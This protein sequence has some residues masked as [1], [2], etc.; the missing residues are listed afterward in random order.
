VAGASSERNGVPGP[1]NDELLRQ[2]ARAAE[3][4]DADVERDLVRAIAS[5]Q[6]VAPMRADP[7]T[8]ESG[9]WATA[10]PEGRTQ[11]VAF[12]DVAA[13]TAWAGADTPHA[14]V[15]GPEFARI[16]VASDAV[17]LWINPAGPH[18]G[19][20]ERRM[21]DVVAAGETLAF[22]A[23]DAGARTTRLKTTGHGEIRVRR[24]EQSP[25]PEALERLREA[26][27]ASPH[28]HDGRLL[29]ATAPPPVHLLLVLEV[30]PGGDDEAAM[31]DVR[32]AVSRLVP[33]DRFVD[34]M[35]VE[36]GDDEL[37]A[38]ARQLGIPVGAG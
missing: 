31:A 2:M 34:T 19:R 37:L 10:D 22:E 17:A 5:A 4:F 12:T 9:L 16:A 25:P 24:P 14:V 21:I 33:P 13:L 28:I 38:R 15:P 3:H 18:G 35:P 7:A 27:A 36:A 26:I 1:T 11:A 23:G 8:G 20:L 6:L 29:E 32:D 30:P